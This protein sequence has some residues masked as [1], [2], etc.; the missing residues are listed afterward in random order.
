MT[1]AIGSPTTGARCA[2]PQAVLLGNVS[3]RTGGK[4]LEWDA[5]R[6]KAANCPEADNF[7]NREYR[8]GWEL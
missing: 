3:Y 1:L 6:L 7:L 5:D 8:K 2:L 4:K